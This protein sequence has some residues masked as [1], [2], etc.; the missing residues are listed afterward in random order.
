M[1]HGL[2]SRFAFQNAPFYIIVSCDAPVR[3]S[4]SL[5]NDIGSQQQAALAESLGGRKGDW[6]WEDVAVTNAH[7]VN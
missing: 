5:R 2:I 4:K 7:D 1:H 6:T 3:V